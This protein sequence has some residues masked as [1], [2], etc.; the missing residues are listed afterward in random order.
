MPYLPSIVLAASGI[1]F[2]GVLAAR[3]LQA[4]RRFSSVRDAAVTTTADRAGLIRA[5]AAG[6]RIALGQRRRG[7]PNQ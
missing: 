7:R 4:L 3:T 1:L 6:V 5:R 2:L